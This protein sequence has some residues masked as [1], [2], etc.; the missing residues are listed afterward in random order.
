MSNFQ[1]PSPGY[2]CTH[3]H[4]A[5]LSHAVLRQ[6][7]HL[8]VGLFTQKSFLGV[9]GGTPGHSLYFVGFQHEKLIVLDPHFVQDAVDTSQR[10]FPLQSYHCVYPK[11]IPF[12]SMDPSCA[13]GFYCRTKEDY[14]TFLDSVQPFL[15]PPSE[16]IVYPMFA[17]TD[18]SRDDAF[19]LGTQC[20]LTK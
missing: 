1:S 15:L 8:F 5:H 18:G 3:N 17:V 20:M 10:D 7:S 13:L 6:T 19:K 2:S 4:G 14:D 11:K 12:T 16:E 9:I